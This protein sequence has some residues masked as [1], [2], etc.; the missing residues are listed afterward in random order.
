MWVKVTVLAKDDWEGAKAEADVLVNLEF[1]RRIK[2]GEVEDNEGLREVSVLEYGD[3]EVCI[4]DQ[5]PIHLEGAL[6]L[7]RVP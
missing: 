7:G 2:R 4:V 1:V 3:G 5:P 6:H